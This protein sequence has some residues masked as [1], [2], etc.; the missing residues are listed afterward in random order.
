MRSDPLKTPEE[1]KQACLDLQGSGLASIRSKAELDALDK[2][3]EAQT[4]KGSFHWS[5]VVLKPK[6]SPPPK[7]FCTPIPGQPSCQGQAFWG[8]KTEVSVKGDVNSIICILCILGDI[9]RT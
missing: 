8:N 7:P 3:N 6:E 9:T 2:L 4:K 1:A 5:D